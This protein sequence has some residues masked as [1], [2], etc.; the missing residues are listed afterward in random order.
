MY[1][2]DIH[3]AAP[4]TGVDHDGAVVYFGA[5]FSGH[6]WGGD[7]TRTEGRRFHDPVQLGVGIEIAC[8]CEP[9]ETCRMRWRDWYIFA[10]NER[11]DG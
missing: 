7:Q 10:Q 3:Q 1:P 4:A 11:A 9:A 6:N 5:S 2:K 8:V